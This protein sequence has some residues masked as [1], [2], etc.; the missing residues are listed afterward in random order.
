MSKYQETSLNENVV[1]L[2][3]NESNPGFLYSELERSV[4]ESLFRDGPK[5]FYS[6]LS[7]HRLEPFLSPEE[8]NQV[9]SWVEDRHTEVIENGDVGSENSSEMQEVSGQYFP[10][11]SDTPAPCLELGWPEKD[12]W[13]GVERVMIYRNPPVEQAPHIREVIRR[14]LQGATRLIAIV[15]DRLTDSTVI[16]DL[17]SAALRG[18]IVYIIL[19]QRPARDNLT[20]N[21]LEHPNIIVRILGGNTFACSDGKKVVG[22]LKENFILVDLDTVV[23]GSYSLTWLD[24]HLHRQLVTVLSGPSVELFDREFRILYAASLPV[25]DSWKAA[26]PKDLPVIDKTL[27]QPEPNTPKQ[28]LQDCPPSPPPPTAGS[29]IDWDTLGVFQ[30]TKDSPEE[31]QDLPE[32]LEELP[33]FHKTGPDWQIWPPGGGVTDPHINECQDENK[34]YRFMPEPRH[35]LDHQ[36]MFWSAQKPERLPYGFLTERN[37]GLGM[38]R[39]RDIWMERKF[40]EDFGSFSH[41]QRHD[42]LPS[43]DRS[44]GENTIPEETTPGSDAGP[45]NQKKPIIVCVPQNERSWQLGDILKKI[46]SDQSTKGLPSNMAKNPI[47]KSSLDLSSPGPETLQRSQSQANLYDGFPMTP[48]LALMKKR[49]NEAKSSF[50]RSLQPLSRPRSF[51]LGLKKSAFL[52]EHTNDEDK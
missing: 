32:Y 19:N 21:Q 49:N 3:A 51:S 5:A 27:Y 10:E 24:A 30:K 23:L 1:I 52:R 41:T 11:L 50:L 42:Y 36:A 7:A 34:L 2:P 13:D 8:V 38:P 44:M 46:S 17:H 25:P 9:S 43:L 45:H 31:D 29:P 12:R 48:A 37:E 20:Q 33:M 15:V 16:A 39:L 47:S 14:L 26:K 40:M 35:T 6:K 28:D 4:L 18:V 22:E